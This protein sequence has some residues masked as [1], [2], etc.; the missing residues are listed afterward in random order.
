MTKLDTIKVAMDAVEDVLADVA[1]DVECAVMNAPSMNVI[2]HIVGLI[3][4]MAYTVQGADV[5]SIDDMCKPD[6]YDGIMVRVRRYVEYDASVTPFSFAVA[7]VSSSIRET[8]TNVCV[9]VARMQV[10]PTYIVSMR[11]EP[12]NVSDTFGTDYI[13]E[14]FGTLYDD[15]EL[16]RR[17]CKDVRTVSF[18]S[19]ILMNLLTDFELDSMT[20]EECA[21]VLSYGT[22]IIENTPIY[23]GDIARIAR[24]INEWL[25]AIE[26]EDNYTSRFARRVELDSTPYGEY[27]SE[28]HMGEWA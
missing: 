28:V 13:G 2:R 26:S 1:A 17:V 27:N 5:E 16:D 3:M 23:K 4:S 7:D 20:Y 24:Y 12:Y 25:S 9:A 14:E 8:L 22:P 19:T 6:V 11:L 15:I 18:R 21:D 10:N